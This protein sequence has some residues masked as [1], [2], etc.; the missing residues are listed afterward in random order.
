MIII[1][2]C[3][4]YL[5]MKINE[6]YEIVGKELNIEPKLIKE[7]YEASW[8]F[9]RETIISLPIKGETIEDVNKL[10]AS[11]N[12]PS[13]GKLHI[14]ENRLRVVKNIEKKIKIRENAEYQEDQT[15]VDIYCNN[16][17]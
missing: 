9:I 1:L 11:F 7:A 2:N 15:N 8:S 14:G 4:Y 10:K 16:N 3:Y 17:G 5:N 12:L 6:M 13:L